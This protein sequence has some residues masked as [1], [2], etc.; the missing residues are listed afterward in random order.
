[1]RHAVLYLRRSTDMQEQ[2]LGDQRKALEV[3]AQDHSFVILKEFVDD[4]VSGT[5]TEGRDA[6]K[7]MIK[8]ALNGE[9]DFE[10][11][12][13]WDIRRFSRGDVDEAGYYRHLL[14]Q[15][16]VEVLYI[17]E[18]LTGDDVDDL[19]IG[20]KQWLARQESKDK[21]KVTIRGML[22]L[23]EKGHWAGGT[24]P[25]GYDRA[26]FDSTGQ[27]LRVVKTGEPSRMAPGDYVKLA[28]GDPDFVKTVQ[29]LFDLFVNRGLG[30][31][32]IASLFNQEGIP[33][34]SGGRWAIVTVQ[35]LLRN[36]V[37]KGAVVWNKTSHGRFHVV[38]KEGE[39]TEI[40]SL[41]KRSAIRIIHHPPERW[42]VVEDAHEPLISKE[43]FAAAQ[44]KRRTRSAALYRYNG[45]GAD[46]PYLLTSLI[47]CG[48]CGSRM[49]GHTKRRKGHVYPMYVCGG[50]SQ[51]GRSVCE[52]V[53]V[54]Q[55]ALEGYAVRR[56]KERY[57]ES[58]QWL[59][60]L[61]LLKAEL[62]AFAQPNTDALSN[63]NK[64][65]G[66]IEQKINLLLDAIS[67]DNA[68]LINEKL[69]RLREEMMR[70]E[71]QRTALT[72]R[73]AITID[74][75][76][77]AEEM[78]ASLDRMEEVL[79]QATFRERKAFVRNFVG[80]YTVYPDRGEAVVG[81]YKIPQHDRIKEALEPLTARAPSDH[82][83]TACVCPVA[84][85]S[86][87]E[88][89]PSGVPAPFSSS[90]RCL[91]SDPSAQKSARP[92]RRS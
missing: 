8:T 13:V 10:A 15:H 5:S 6:F 67:P 50:F 59:N 47:R 79:T 53:Y 24:A 16:G 78:L 23:I 61:D 2:S 20:T 49:Y 68:V 30:Y 45:R 57:L 18:N 80:S 44:A 54:H 21:S 39:R 3:Y 81:F 28:P 60:L 91:P 32:A 83:E 65:L 87:S 26:I 38:R 29:R 31:R 69:R 14:R 64:R 70:L 40:H 19:I 89:D 90:S 77:A 25:Y 7:A 12:L 84:P 9:R 33:G 35:T 52:E 22:S 55:D 86:S 27:L 42:I 48:Q 82:Q 76:R 75:T 17:A 46:S 73:K 41:G 58:G 85:S 1:M 34:P 36:P 72:Q 88:N 4:A 11:I 63:T 74:V 43:L 66:D 37:Y 56:I 71:Q 51:G 92:Q 62:E